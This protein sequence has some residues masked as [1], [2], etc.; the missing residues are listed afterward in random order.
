M[1]NPQQGQVPFVCENGHTGTMDRHA[2][3]KAA[4]PQRMWDR[5]KRGL[6][7]DLP[8]RAQDCP[9]CKRNK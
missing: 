8:I 4:H 9:T 7:K 1:A 3:K 2:A 5:Y 6:I